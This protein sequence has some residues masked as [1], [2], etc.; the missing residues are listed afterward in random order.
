MTQS[1]LKNKKYLVIA[2]IIILLIWQS[3]AII[4]N[5]RLLMPSFFDVIENLYNLICEVNFMKLIVSSI[6]R[7]I[8]SFILSLFISIVLAICSYYS[9]FIYNL[10]YPIILFI[11]AIPTMAFIVLI[12]IWTSKEFAPIIIGIV[13]SFPIF[14]D[15][16]LNTLLNINKD[17]IQMCKVYEISNIDR[18]NAIIIPSIIIELKKVINSTLALIF[19]V[20]ISGEVYAQ[21]KYGIGSMIQLEKMQL[22]TA[23]VI[24]WMII[25]TVI[26]YGFDFILEKIFLL[27]KYKG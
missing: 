20:V 4:I 13:I 10:L 6:I 27:N 5:N 23:A 15:V 21:P 7:C 19:K 14:Y 3:V 24:A 2:S 16:I 11:K 22:N 17:L 25:I 26:V 9:K 12:L 18:I 8:E 1:S